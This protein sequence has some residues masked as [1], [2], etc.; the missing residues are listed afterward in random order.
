M[1]A[2]AFPGHYQF[3]VMKT[4]GECLPTKNVIR[5]NGPDTRREFSWAELLGCGYWLCDLIFAPAAGEV[6]T[7]NRKNDCRSRP[8]MTSV[9]LALVKLGS[10][11]T[12][13][14]VGPC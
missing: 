14:P 3:R 8:P 9:K 12:D 1:R 10:V 5:F 4:F 6:S 2:V 7:T 13:V 11:K